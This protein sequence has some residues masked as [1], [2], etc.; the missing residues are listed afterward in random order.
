MTSYVIFDES[1][2]SRTIL[3]HN[4]LPEMNLDEFV[5][6]TRDLL[7]PS[8]S[9]S[10]SDADRTWF[11]F[12]GRNLPTALDCIDYL[13]TFVASRN[14]EQA[15]ALNKVELKI[16]VELEKPGRE[17]LEELASRADVVFYSR[18]WAEGEQYPSAER[19]LIDQAWF[20]GAKFPKSCIS[21]RLLVCTWGDTGACALASQDRPDKDIAGIG[22]VHS[23][24]YTAD[25]PII[26]TTGAGDTFIAGMLFGL[27]CRATRRI[28][29]IIPT[30][31]SLKQQLDFAN[32]LAG[33]KILQSGFQGLGQLDRSLRD[34]LESE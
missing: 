21:E 16:S 15:L 31:W 3:N 22:L 5:A 18:S 25:K 11:H 32:G 8:H 6:S 27:I 10:R 24:A 1:S 2:S 17:N 29:L 13:R 26:D 20:L 7:E 30:C 12:E 14:K 33:R 4:A 23:L 19:C 28:K 34:T 9:L